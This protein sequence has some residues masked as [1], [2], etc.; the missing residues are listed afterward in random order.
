MIDTVTFF[1]EQYETDLSFQAKVDDAVRRILRAKY[2]LGLFDRPLSDPA[3]QDLP[4][5]AEHRDTHV[6]KIA[7]GGRGRLLGDTGNRV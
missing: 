4:G 3:L 1:H 7:G 6:P 5:S 2:M